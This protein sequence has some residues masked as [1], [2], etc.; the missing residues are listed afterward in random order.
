MFYLQ[1]LTGLQVHSGILPWHF[2]PET[3]IPN[4]VRTDKK[5]R[6]DWINDAGT[7][8]HVYS[9][10]EGMNQNLRVTKNRD[11]DEGNPPVKLWGLTADYDSRQAEEF[12]LK[13][14][15]TLAVPPNWIERTLSGNWRYVWEF[16]KPAS[17]PSYDFTLHFLKNFEKF[18]FPV[19]NAM[20]GF[21]RGAWQ[22]PARLYTNSCDWRRLNESPLSKEIVTGWLVKASQSFQWTASEMGTVIPLDVVQPKLK[23]R[24]PR[25]AD[26][27]GEFV[28]NSQGPSFWV[29]G[30]TSPKSAFVRET[31]IQTF[32]DHAHKA[33]FTWSDLLGYQFVKDYEALAIGRAVENIYFDGRHYFRQIANESWKP[34]ERHDIALHLK[35]ERKVSPKP[36]K[37]VSGVE[38]CLAH[39][40]SHQSVVGAAPF[41]MKPA[42]LLR[43]NNLEVLNINT[44]R[45]LSPASGQAVWGEHGPFSWL[46][47]YLDAF[48][49]P[50]EQLDYFLSWWSHFYRAAFHQIPRS[51][52][53]IFI[54]GETGVGKTLLST[55]IVSALVG[56]SA[57]ARDY[58][59]GEDK[60]GSELFE[61]ALWC[62]DDATLTA[63]QTTRK[64]F[65]G[66]IK[67]MAANKKFRYHAKF[68]IPLMVEWHGRVIVTLNRD[69][70]SIL[71]LPELESSILDKIMLFKTADETVEF[72]EQSE[73]ES[74]LQRELPFFARFLLDYKIPEHCKGKSR[75][76]IK[77][78][79]EAS[80][81]QTAQQSSPAAGF[82]E[83]LDD[84][85]ARYFTGNDSQRE[86]WEGNAYQLH[87]EICG[88]LDAR[89]AMRTYS[90]NLV[91]RALATLKNQGQPIECRDALQRIWRI[92]SPKSKALVAP[93]TKPTTNG[94][95]V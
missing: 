49:D 5:K 9:F 17:L 63:E 84:W 93:T 30:S 29:D 27:P 11:A 58:L 32:A 28:L 7:K 59:L 52:Q 64:K 68:R 14:A 19:S 76:G 45:V 35:A 90:V 65:S 25:F 4:E 16:E 53:N 55:V 91:R 62:V 1:R 44:R 43:I 83:I 82:L 56:G 33:F 85:K 6:S 71:V 79:H 72:P 46:S 75:F 54:A 34:F 42:G 39:I 77:P 12:V 24:Y 60:F 50:K 13:I 86:Y 48:F 18:G 92:Y 94:S 3:P 73:L 88:H 2:K 61:V 80:L 70:E 21:D 20:I 95:N 31:G 10:F 41:I 47:R 89:D 69:P 51:G 87:K 67:A 23:E 15:K 22:D 26:W 78:Y 8:H 66:M 40:Q 36:D 74:I 57:D 38:R 37:G 81:F